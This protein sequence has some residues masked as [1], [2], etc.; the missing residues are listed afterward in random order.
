[1]ESLSIRAATIADVPLILA[2][3]RKK[4]AFDA[5]M[6]NFN[7][8]LETSEQAIEH[9]MFAAQPFA[10]VRF[11]SSG[12]QV[13]GFALYYFRYSSFRGRASL[14]LDDLYVNEA[15]R[16]RRLG[17]ALMQQ[18]AREALAHGCTEMAWTASAK[19]EAGIRF[20]VRLGA[21]EYDRRGNLVFFR[22]DASA[23]VQ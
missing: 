5:T 2:F 11:A 16:G 17:A 10:H 23:L 9:T 13:G 7:G 6:G 8:V 12:E 20:Y 15:M 18:L 3:I 21:T 1:M 22:I 19:N 14:W 4:A